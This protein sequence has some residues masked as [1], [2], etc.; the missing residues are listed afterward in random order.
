M[1]VSEPAA[2]KEDSDKTGRSLAATR[3]PCHRLRP[4]A[5]AED[6]RVI[7]YDVRWHG[8]STGDGGDYSPEED[9]YALLQYLEA[10]QA[11]IVGLSF[12]GRIGIDF[13]LWHPEMAPARWPSRTPPTWSTWRSRRSSKTIDI[14]TYTCLDFR[15]C[16]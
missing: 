11:V 10:E 5:F 16:F 9:L 7:R 14:C 15:V 2:H 1:P 8:D 4:A 13:T 6:C 12:G 3:A